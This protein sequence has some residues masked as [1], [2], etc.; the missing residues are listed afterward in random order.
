MGKVKSVLDS[1]DFKGA[2]M[3]SIDSKNIVIRFSEEADYFRIF[4]KPLWFV[5]QSTKRVLMRSSN[6]HPFTEPSVVPVWVA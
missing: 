6:F 5:H 2:F 1:F 4:L 3:S